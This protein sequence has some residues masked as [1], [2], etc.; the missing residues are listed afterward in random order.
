MVYSCR[1]RL[2]VLRWIT[3]SSLRK[4]RYL[5]RNIADDNLLFSLAR[6]CG[7]EKVSQIC[8]TSPGAKKAVM[9]SIRVRRKAT[10]RKPSWVA[11]LAPR[12]RRAPLMSTP[13]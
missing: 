1:K 6:S 7:S 8:E 13:M 9:N 4:L 2:S 12:Q 10:F 5:S 3:P 11:V